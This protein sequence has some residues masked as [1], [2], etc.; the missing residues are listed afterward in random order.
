M[1]AQRRLNALTRATLTELGRLWE[2]LE[3]SFSAIVQRRRK[4]TQC[5]AVVSQS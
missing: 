3:R 4:P 1:D 5:G 2:E